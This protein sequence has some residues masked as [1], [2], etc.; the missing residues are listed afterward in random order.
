MDLIIPDISVCNKFIST[1]SMKKIKR[2]IAS[3]NNDDIKKYGVKGTLTIDEFLEKIKEQGNK[4]YVCLQEFKYDGGK[5]CYFFPSADRI[6]NYKSHTKS[7]IAASCLFCNIRMFKGINEKKCGLCEGLNHVYQGDI[8]TKSVLFRSLENS[9][10]RIKEYINDINKTPEELAIKKEK[11]L[12][13][14]MLCMDIFRKND[15][16]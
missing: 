10:D 5:W 1:D 2:N 13:F 4:C 8:I 6:Y 9:D 7:N 15:S 11:I 16:N 14:N 3:S 12:K